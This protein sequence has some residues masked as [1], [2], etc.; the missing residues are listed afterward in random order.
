MV[1]VDFAPWIAAFAVVG[2]AAITGPVVW[3]LQRLDKRNRQDH[4]H[5]FSMQTRILE[6]LDEVAED[7]KEAKVATIE[8]GTM[9]REHIVWHAHHPEREHVR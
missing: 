8:N 9:I 1:A 5:N 6:R 7:A 4:E 3:A 2:A